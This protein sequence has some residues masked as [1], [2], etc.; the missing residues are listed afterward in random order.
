M[1]VKVVSGPMTEKRKEEAYKFIGNIILQKVES[2]EYQ[3]E[4]N[5]KEVV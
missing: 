5:K 2:G 4:R 1:N 3:K